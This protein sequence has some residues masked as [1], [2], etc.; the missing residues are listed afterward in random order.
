MTGSATPWFHGA[1][2]ALGL[3]VVLALW[4]WRRFRLRRATQVLCAGLFVVLL[5]LAALD[6][7]PEWPVGLFVLSDPL[8]ALVHTLAGRTA[9]W[10]LSLSLGFVVLAVLMGRVFCSH[11]CP[12]GT[13]L[14]LSDRWVTR[15]P[16]ARE[17]R[18]GFRRA[19]KAKFVI[20]LSVVSAAVFGFNLLGFFDPL[21]LLSRF[22]AT[23]FYP[24]V[25]LL[26]ALGFDLVQLVASWAGWLDLAY[27]EPL[28][29][30]ASAGAPLS[31]SLLALLL[32]LSRLQPR[33]F[34]RG[35]C[36]L[37]AM[38]AWMGRWA[39]YRKQVSSA[40]NSCNK[41]A[42]SCPTGAI[43]Y[44]TADAPPATDRS[45]CIVCLQCVHVCPER[46]VE[47]GFTRSAARHSTPGVDLGRRGL[48]GGALGGLAAGLTMRI[49]VAHPSGSPL[50]L[51]R[52]HLELLR[53]PG[54]LPEPEFLSRCVRCDA[55]VRACVTNTLQPDWY[56]AGLE[57][58]WAPR[59]D[60]RHAACDQSCNACGQICPT[61]A[62]R[63]LSL[64]ERLHARVGTAVVIRD[65]C[66]PWSQNDRCL[67]CEVQCPY[68]AIRL[69]RDEQHDVGVPVVDAHKCNGC[70]KCEDRCPV[71]GE[72]AIRVTPQG[73][74]RLAQ[75]SY[76]QAARDA[77]LRFEP[78]AREPHELR[79]DDS[80]Q[81]APEPAP[82]GSEPHE[83]HMDD[84]RLPGQDL[85]RQRRSRPEGGLTDPD[86]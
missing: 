25:V 57:G 73:E 10:L 30:P 54:A 3:T 55:C 42:E 65:R 47:F 14:D 46:A 58:L 20:L 32:L 4:V 84:S 2:V 83:F 17:N 70:G 33:F 56:R 64:A 35:I 9:V 76:L 74:I 37:G 19:R 61:E 78:R 28:L 86:W 13:L 66:L 39:P 51:P 18:A 24:A 69:V 38:L 81:P 79:L 62:I 1:F 59:M 22:A 45:E 31:V 41:C 85:E 15:R 72:A 6:G 29:V 26:Q 16:K 7:R 23:L 44:A 34:C 27:A 12:M 71:V 52:R 40:C 82:S 53:P 11:V 50:Q 8:V 80:P 68:Q 48:V 77:G 36:P 49:D 60:L 63:P 5:W 21:V 67:V 75:G 43:A